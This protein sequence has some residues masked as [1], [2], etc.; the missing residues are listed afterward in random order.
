MKNL[1]SERKISVMGIVNITGDSYF[2]DSR[3]L[4]PDGKPDSGKIAGRIRKMF[5]EGAGIVDIGACSTR[6]GAGLISETEEWDR[7]APVMDIIREQFPGR[8]F[9]I[10]T[11][12][13]GIVEKCASR[14]GKFT[15]NDISAGEDDPRMLETAGSL[16]LPYIAM[17]KRGTPATMQQHARYDNVTAEVIRFL[18]ERLRQLYELGVHDVLVDPGFG[19]AKTLEQN[20]RLLRDLPHFTLLEAPLLV[21]VSRKRMVYQLLDT[22][23]QHALNGTTAVHMMALAGGASVLRVHDVKEAVEAVKVWR[24]VKGDWSFAQD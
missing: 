7:L 11:F 14:I 2:A 9:S 8:M 1:R 5:E 12:R 4:G 22:D 3:C 10:D 20:Y 24:A 18:A 13:A 6:P 23:P 16:G 21:G 17:H 15:V 19:F